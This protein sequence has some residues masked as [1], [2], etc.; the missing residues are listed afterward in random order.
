MEAKKLKITKIFTI[1]LRSIGR[2]LGVGEGDFFEVK[3][4]DVKTGEIILKAVKK[5]DEKC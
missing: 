2:L 1:S 5:E 4:I 3:N